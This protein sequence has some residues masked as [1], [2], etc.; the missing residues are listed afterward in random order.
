MPVHPGAPRWFCGVPTVWE[1]FSAPLT[2]ER[3]YLTATISR[4]DLEFRGA[5]VYDRE[6]DC[7][8]IPAPPPPSPPAEKIYF[9]G[10]PAVWHFFDHDISPNT[11]YYSY[12][13]TRIEVMSEGVDV[14]HEAGDCACIP[15]PPP[16]PMPPPPAPSPPRPPVPS[17]PPPP[18][19]PPLPPPSPSQPSQ[20]PSLPPPPPSPPPPPPPPPLPPP[21]P[22]PPP[23]SPLPLPPPPPPP[24]PSPVVTPAPTIVAGSTAPAS[25]L[26]HSAIV[27]RALPYGAVSGPPLGAVVVLVTGSA[28]LA[29]RSRAVSLPSQQPLMADDASDGALSDSSLHSAIAP[30]RASAELL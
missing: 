10:L 30:H 11:C 28:L 9:C 20:S 21:P 17:T 4:E 13:L 23:P 22:P 27:A 5:K 29:W 7:R 1:F 12:S 25:A 3:C 2:P 16:S 26:K 18:P 14:Y 8:C 19:S 6:E 15:P 24:R